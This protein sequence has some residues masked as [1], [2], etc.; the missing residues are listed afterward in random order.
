[1][2]MS[3]ICQSAYILNKFKIKLFNG[4]VKPEVNVHIKQVMWAH[5]FFK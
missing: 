1:M 2:E 4:G 3:I 5:L